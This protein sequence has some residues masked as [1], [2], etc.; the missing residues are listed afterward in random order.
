MG[1]PEN[2]GGF[3]VGVMIQLSEIVRMNV[4]PFDSREQAANYLNWDRFNEQLPEI[5]LSEADRH[6]TRCHRLF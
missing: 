4:H 2:W 3:F 1:P 6:R 5:D